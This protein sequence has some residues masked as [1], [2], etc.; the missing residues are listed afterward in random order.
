MGENKG[1]N[2]LYHY[3][4]VMPPK[5]SPSS[6]QHTEGEKTKGE[7]RHPRKRGASA[8]IITGHGLFT[9]IK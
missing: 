4:M 7:G 3:D 8:S 1:S 9:G 6:V 5:S 2:G